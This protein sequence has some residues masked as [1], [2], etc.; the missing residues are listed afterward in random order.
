MA[1]S[2]F[3]QLAETITYKPGYQIEFRDWGDA[4]HFTLTVNTT[5][6]LIGEPTAIAHKKM[7]PWKHMPTFKD[8]IEWVWYEIQRAEI[9]EAA[10]FYKVSGSRYRNPHPEERANQ[11]E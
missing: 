5:C 8:A 2:W 3:P 10:E 1:P 9:H 6:S 7:I 4:L 11:H